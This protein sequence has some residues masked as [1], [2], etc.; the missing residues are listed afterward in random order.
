ML[1][2]N[3]INVK[4]KKSLILISE[5][6]RFKREMLMIQQLKKKV[7]HRTWQIMEAAHSGDNVSQS[8]DFFIFTLILLNVLVAILETVGSYNE[9]YHV[10]FHLF[11]TVSVLV[12]TIEYLVR[13]SACTADPKYQGSI[14]GRIRY[15][16]TPLAIIDL[17][18][19]LPFY[20]SFF[21][22]DLRML[23]L[24][25]LARIFRIAKL[26]R[27]SNSIKIIGKVFHNKREELTL[28]FVSIF[29]LV[30]ISSTVMFHVENAAQPEAFKDI[31]STMWWTI[32]TLTTVGYGDMF[33]VTSLGKFFAAIISLMGIAT[34]ALPTGIIGAGFVEE[35]RLSREKREHFLECPFCGEMF[36]SNLIEKY[37]LREARQIAKDNELERIAEKVSS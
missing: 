6:I 30:I 25:R 35:I 18:A 1:Y 20:L 24:L 14:K 17:L 23:R 22:F 8:F 26:A 19:I 32:V 34:F 12:F 27:Y 13:I 5:D 11:D 9:R 21:V 15:M 3:L 7:Q 2:L 16:L 10:F 31:P 4:R 33:P 36:D 28:I 29:F 37:S